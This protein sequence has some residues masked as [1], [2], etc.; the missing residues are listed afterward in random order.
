[1]PYKSCGADN[2]AKFRGDSKQVYAELA[3]IDRQLQQCNIEAARL[4]DSLKAVAAALCLNPS[5]IN[6]RADV[7]VVAT[8]R[9][10]SGRFF[11]TVDLAK[12]RRVILNAR[13][14]QM[15]RKQLER[16]LLRSA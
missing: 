9:R 16:Q 4:G 2:A 12:I 15:E 5:E 1:M 11:T 10:S 14:L 6:F 8:Q 3:E 13:I 7:L